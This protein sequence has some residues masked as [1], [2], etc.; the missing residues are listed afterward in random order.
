MIDALQTIV[1]VI[2]TVDGFNNRV[3]RRWPK[4]NAVVPSCLIS[5][6]SAYPTQTDADGNEIKVQLTYSVDINAK[7]ADQADML[8]EQVI[9]KLAQY[10]FHRTGDTDFYDDAVKASRRILTFMGTV[11]VRGNT[12][13]Q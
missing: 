6:I 7:S 1:E 11:D 8:A 3:Y 10:N 2:R 12:F 4:T 13:T 5:R 9:D